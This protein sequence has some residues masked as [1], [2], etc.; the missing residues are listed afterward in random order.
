MST[1]AD[2]LDWPILSVKIQPE[3]S[4]RIHQAVKRAGLKSRPEWLLSVITKALEE[5]EAAQ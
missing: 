5:Q 2:K 4:Y 3:L 1:Y